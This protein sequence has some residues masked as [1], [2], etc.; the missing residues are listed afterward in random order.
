M[1]RS[2]VR[3]ASFALVTGLCLSASAGCGTT[4]PAAAVT[5]T[6]GGVVSPQGTA[7]HVIQASGG[8]DISITLVSLSPLSTISVGVGLGIFTSNQCVIQYANDGF[9]VSTN[10]QTSLNAKGSYCV[11]VYDT[12]QVT[13]NVTYGLKVVHP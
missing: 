6:L 12:G 11:S 1:F 5:E 8:G 4:A 7:F 3:H 9:K 2:S 10:W 13:Q